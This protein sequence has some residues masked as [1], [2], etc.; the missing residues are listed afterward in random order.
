MREVHLGWNSETIGRSEFKFVVEICDYFEVI[1]HLEIT[2]KGVRQLVRV[3]FQ[4]DKN[5][6]DLE[7]IPFLEVEGPLTPHPLP[8]DGEEGIL[9]IWNRHPVSIAAIGFEGLHIIPPYTIDQQ[10]LNVTIRGLAEG[11]SGFLKTVRILFPPDSVKV[12]DMEHFENNMINVLTPKQIEATTIAVKYGYYE[13]PRTVSMRELSEIS[14][15]ARSTLQEHLSKAEAA[16]M[17]LAAKSQ[18]E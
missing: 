4:A 15:I 12:V 5:P 18:L 7:N 1:A 3:K 14:G 8:D 13:N 10:G 6:N 9:V 2:P 16:L 11:I 17:I